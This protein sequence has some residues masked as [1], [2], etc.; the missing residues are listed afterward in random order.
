[1]TGYEQ[2]RSELDVLLRDHGGLDGLA[3]EMVQCGQVEAE[4]HGPDDDARSSIVLW[5]ILAIVLALF[6]WAFAW[7]ANAAC[8]DKGG[9]GYRDE[10]G[11]C[12]SWESLGRVCGCPPTTRCKADKPEP[13][14]DR[15]AADGCEIQSFRYLHELKPNTDEKPRL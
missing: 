11:H 12:V 8:G 4:P 1:M 6:L 14:A 5:V 7:P 13:E 15:A 9:P 2:R 3:R 10:N